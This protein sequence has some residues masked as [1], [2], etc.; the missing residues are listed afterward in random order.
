MDT[1][2][3]RT[4]PMAPELDDRRTIG[5]RIVAVRIAMG[6]QRDQA[7]FAR[8]WGVTRSSLSLYEIGDRRPKLDQL[9]KL[10]RFFGISYDWLLHG[11]FGT[12]PNALQKQLD[13]AEQSIKQK[14]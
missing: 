12:M 9:A 5:R 11:T 8:K 2:V 4:G 14:R 6:F 10:R 13:E 3:Q 1:Q 7:G